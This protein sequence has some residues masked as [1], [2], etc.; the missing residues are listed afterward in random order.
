MKAT[1]RENYIQFLHLHDTQA[2]TPCN[3]SYRYLMNHRKNF[4]LTNAICNRKTNTIADR[5]SI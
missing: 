5:I 4:E 2:Y 3:Y 1:L